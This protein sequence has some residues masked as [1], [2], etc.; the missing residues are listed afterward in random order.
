MTLGTPR[1]ISLDD[2][3]VRTTGKVLYSET[4]PNAISDALLGDYIAQ[5]E[6]IVENHLRPRYLVSPI[7]N[8]DGGAFS[9]L[10]P[11]SLNYLRTMF[12]DMSIIKLLKYYY[13][14]S[15]GVKGN[16]FIED[17]V[18]SYMGYL[19]DITELD[20][21]GKF[22][23]NPLTDVATNPASFND[24]SFVPRPIATFNPNAALAAAYAAA[25]VNLP[26]ISWSFPSLAPAALVRGRYYGYC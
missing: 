12:I 9:T 14:Q 6:S 10:P 23:Y 15:D 17:L 21:S 18:T 25:S 24:N 22:L 3:K 7:L 26:A 11:S 16:K 20:P 4:D 13:G 8:K 19:K 2:V 1:Y 5:G